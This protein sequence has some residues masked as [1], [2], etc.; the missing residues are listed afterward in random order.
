MVPL[1]NSF[2]KE[3]KDQDPFPTKITIT[4]TQPRCMDREHILRFQNKWLQVPKSHNMFYATVYEK[5]GKKT[6]F[7]SKLWGQNGHNMEQ[8]L[9]QLKSI[10]E[11][12]GEVTEIEIVTHLT[13]GVF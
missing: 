10:T 8:G 9:N 5:E 13:S 4:K 11:V 3:D 12:R 7:F 2:F 1:L 6:P